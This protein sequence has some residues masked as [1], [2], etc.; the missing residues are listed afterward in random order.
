MPAKQRK[1][2]PPASWASW[3]TYARSFGVDRTN[4]HA[5]TTFNSGSGL[6]IKE[7]LLLRT[8]LHEAKASRI[9]PELKVQS[10]MQQVCECLAESKTFQLYLKSIDTKALPG[11]PDLGIF[12]I[13]YSQQYQVDDMLKNVKHTHHPINEEIVNSSLISFLTA[14][15]LESQKVNALWTAHRAEQVATFKSTKL[16][17]QIDGHLRSTHNKH[18]ILEAKANE[19]DIHEPYVSYQ[20]A[21]EIVTA[22]V[23]DPP[24]GLGKERII[25]VSQDG[26]NFYISNALFP[27][28]WKDYILGNKKKAKKE[29]F[30]EVFRYGPWDTRVRKEVDHFAKVLLALA[31]RATAEEEER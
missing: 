25:L 20:E 6:T 9:V 22:I 28:G 17:C 13:P 1:R 30:L 19:R 12:G 11:A 10:Y 14:I 26:R 5:Q 24:K 4:I 15:C 23:E 2:D 18:I 29:D 8:L 31:I 21:G 27:D 7:F 3:S 16:V